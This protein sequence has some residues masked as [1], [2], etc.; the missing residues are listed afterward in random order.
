MSTKN[1]S[2]QEKLAKLDE[3]VAWFQSDEFELEEA[4]EKYKAAEALASEI[5][6]RLSEF[7]NEITV[8][9]QKFDS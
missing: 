5:E 8:L 1:D 4:L 7:K 3:L 2:L 6:T 9:K